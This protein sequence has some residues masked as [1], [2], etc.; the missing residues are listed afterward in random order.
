MS[1]HLTQ[2]REMNYFF[3]M[4]IDFYLPIIPEA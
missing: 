1:V 2:K 4:Q 3:Y